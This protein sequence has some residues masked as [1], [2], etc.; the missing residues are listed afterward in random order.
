MNLIALEIVLVS[1]I[2][3]IVTIA[4]QRKFSNIKRI[5]EIR[6]EMNIHQAD[7]KKMNST[8]PKEEIDAKQKKMMDL[9]SEMM[10]H[11]LRASLILLP[12]FAV[13]VYLILPYTF[14]NTEFSFVF[15]GFTLTYRT[16]FVGACVVLGLAVQAVAAAYDKMAAKKAA[17]A[18]QI[19]T[20][21]V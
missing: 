19:T 4:L 17:T 14:G 21:N 2:Y 20:N 15:L 3:V 10:R 18:T 5:K 8:T 7:M 9:T 13:V 1:L 12:V 6:N 16:F 11:Q